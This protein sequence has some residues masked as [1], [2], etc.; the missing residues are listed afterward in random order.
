M[1][2]VTSHTMTNGKIEEVKVA[3]DGADWEDGKDRPFDG[4]VYVKE[5]DAE[6]KAKLKSRMH[7]AVDGKRPA[8]TLFSDNDPDEAA[9]VFYVIINEWGKPEAIHSL[10][11]L[12][13]YINKHIDMY[14]IVVEDN[15]I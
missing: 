6:G 7:D 8:Y 9:C 11:G 10:D 4:D 13:R 1:Y 14:M 5:M 3:M 15:L 12:C 2:K